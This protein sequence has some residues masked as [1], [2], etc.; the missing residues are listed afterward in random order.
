MSKSVERVIGG[1]SAIS[2]EHAMRERSRRHVTA[3]AIRASL[4]RVA[5]HA[6]VP[7]APQVLR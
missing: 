2:I 5:V 1:G 4:P 6:S 3:A 7:N